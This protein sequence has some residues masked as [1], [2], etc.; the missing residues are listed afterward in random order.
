MANKVVI[1]TGAAQGI[2]RTYALAMARQGARICVSDIVPPDET[3]TAVLAEGAEAMGI[4]CDV[5]DQASVDA[6]VAAALGAFGRIDVLVNNAALFASLRMRSFMD[7]D[8]QEW[9]KVMT[10]N[11]RGT[12]QVTK[13]VVPSMRATGGGSIINIASATVFKGSPL[14]AHYVASKGA[15]VAMTRALAREVGDANIRI[16]ALAPGLVMSEGVQDHP[17]WLESSKSIVASR[18]IKR[19]SQPEDMVGALLFLASDDSEFVTGQTLVVDG[20][21]VMH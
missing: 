17:G 8:L 3:L 4:R 16:N 19:E 14:L 12:W 21:S 6:M 10:V 18:A 11:V 5:T 7:L 1:I 2:G 20:G 9:D 13:A 15:V